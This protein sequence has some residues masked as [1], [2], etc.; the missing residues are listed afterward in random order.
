[1]QRN[2]MN[3]NDVFPIIDLIR[4]QMKEDP[5]FFDVETM[6]SDVEENDSGG[7]ISLNE[8][9]EMYVERDE[10]NKFDPTIVSK[11]VIVYV[12]GAVE[13]LNINRGLDEEIP[14]SDPE[15]MYKKHVI[16]TSIDTTI[17]FEGSEI[18]ARA[19]IIRENGMFKKIDFEWNGG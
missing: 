18:N 8:V 19:S 10:S 16:V 9:D 14:K 12:G 3:T 2:F 4:R 7:Y 5:Q 1:M 11:I 15:Y 13:T 17:A 6:S